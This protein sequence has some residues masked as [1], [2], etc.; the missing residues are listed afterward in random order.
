MSLPMQGEWIEISM[1]GWNG[2]RS[3]T[4]LPMQGEWIEIWRGAA[5]RAMI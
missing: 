2:N 4:S 3:N 1:M 5:L